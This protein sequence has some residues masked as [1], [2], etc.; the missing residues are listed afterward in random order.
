M[1]ILENA[2]IPEAIIEIASAMDQDNY[3]SVSK[4]AD[5]AVF[6][7]KFLSLREFRGDNYQVIHCADSDGLL[8]G[9]FIKPDGTLA[10]SIEAQTYVPCSMREEVRIV[11]SFTY[12]CPARLNKEHQIEAVQEDIN[13]LLDADSTIG[14]ECV[15]A[16]VKQHTSEAQ[17]YHPRDGTPDNQAHRILEGLTSVY[18]DADAQVLALVSY[19]LTDLR[20]LCDKHDLAFHEIDQDAY[21]MYSAEKG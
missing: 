12:D 17:I 13:R 20:H 14:V 9:V 16:L 19:A 4:L 1:Q 3:H 21:K 2:E 11:A 6:I 10:T 8:Y 5:H 18:E 7:A 15:S